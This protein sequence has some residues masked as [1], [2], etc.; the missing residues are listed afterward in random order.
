M[1]DKT[2]P[3]CGLVDVGMDHDVLLHRLEGRDGSACLR[4][5]LAA[6]T[7]RSIMLQERAEKAEAER[8]DAIEN[9]RSNVACADMQIADL[10]H[11]LDEARAACAEMEKHYG[12][13]VQEI[14]EYNPTDIDLRLHDTVLAQPYSVGQP[15]LDR[16]AKAEADAKLAAE[17]LLKM[18][19]N[20]HALA[21]ERDKLLAQCAAFNVALYHAE[22]GLAH[23][24]PAI[25]STVAAARGEKVL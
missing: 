16:L 12:D 2:C 4:R 8:D 7:E 20:H 9:N 11:A 21:V 19:E 1:N 5:Q 25:V 15:L 24:D 23:P 6:E 3:K 14:R 18:G 13:L 10:E 17:A 22:N